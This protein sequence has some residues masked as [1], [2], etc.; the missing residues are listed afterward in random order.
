M[1]SRRSAGN[2]IETMQACPLPSSNSLTPRYQADGEALITDRIDTLLAKLP[3]DQRKFSE[4]GVED[5]RTGQ[6]A[7][8]ST[9]FK[10]IRRIFSLGISPLPPGNPE[11][12]ETALRGTLEDDLASS[13]DYVIALSGGVDSLLLACLL[14]EI[15]GHPPRA[16]TLVSNIPG[17]CE[18][19]TTLRIAERL[20]LHNVE[21][22]EV[23]EESFVA[24]LPEVISACE[25]P[26]YNLH[27]VSKWLFAQELQKRGYLSSITGDG[28]DQ[29]AEGKIS[30]DYLP[31]LGPLFNTHQ[32]NLLCP[33]LSP[34]VV[35][36]IQSMGADPDKRIIRK[37]A[38]EFLPEDFLHRN[39]K[40]CFTPPMDLSRYGTTVGVAS[41]PPEDI[42]NDRELTF[43][44][45][46]NL[47]E[48]S[49]L[50]KE[51]PCAPL[52]E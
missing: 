34:R 31:L 47:L 18:G 40:P 26:L 14:K 16:A 10:H 41:L 49:H 52:P 25:V 9:C 46:L 1:Q 32:M 29:I 12:L 7:E 28:A 4:A 11:T 33:F 37:L 2:F 20:G 3:P 15:L 44:A 42:L 17:Y 45:T 6:I 8:K 38:T 35:K 30:Y 39:K 24:H 43:R 51:K 48:H 50:K 13:D 36:S 23:N 5:F 19:E 21:V 22:I 27:P